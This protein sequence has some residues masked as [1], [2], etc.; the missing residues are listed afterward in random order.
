VAEKEK[1]LPKSRGG[2]KHSPHIVHIF[3]EVLD[4]LA[5]LNVFSGKLEV[6]LGL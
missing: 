1:V 5:M 2:W 3:F 6:Q 4:P